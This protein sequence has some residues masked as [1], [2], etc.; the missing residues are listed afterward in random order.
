MKIYITDIP[1][2]GKAFEGELPGDILKV[3][4][5]GLAS[6]SPIHYRLF[7]L[8]GKES[9]TATGE[10]ETTVQA[11]CGRCSDY[12]PIPLK[13]SHFAV[14]IEPVGDEI[15]LENEIREEILLKLPI[16]PKCSLTSKGLCPYSHPFTMVR[17]E[18]SNPPQSDDFSGGENP[19]DVWGVLDQLKNPEK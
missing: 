9:I 14:D 13:V 5:S 4:D 3:A 12:F 18:D 11:L 10:L 17:Q 1:D 16:V 6:A 8:K 2:E 7:L 19:G 15:H